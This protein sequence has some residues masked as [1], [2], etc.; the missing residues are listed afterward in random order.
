MGTEQTEHMY[1]KRGFI[2]WLTQYSLGSSMMQKG[3]LN[4]QGGYSIHK[5]RC[6]CHPS[7]AFKVKRS[8]G[9][10]QVFSPH[11]KPGAKDVNLPAVE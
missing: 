10:P 3:L 2:K 6:L 8:S 4:S 7:L 9:E 11:C 5:D 1:I